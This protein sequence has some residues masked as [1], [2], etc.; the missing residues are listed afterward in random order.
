LLD[1]DADCRKG[2]RAAAVWFGLR[3]AS[4]SIALRRGLAF[5]SHV[6]QDRM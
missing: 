6:A 4:R 2:I 5:I 1:N 3:M